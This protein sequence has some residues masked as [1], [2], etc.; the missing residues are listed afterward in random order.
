V[1]DSPR[2]EP[3]RG[4]AC[5]PLCACVRCV[6]VC[7][8]WVAPGVRCAYPDPRPSSPTRFLPPGPT[9]DSGAATESGHPDTPVSCAG[10]TS[11]GG[12]R[13]SPGCA[14]CQ[15]KLLRLL[16]AK[17]VAM[18]GVTSH[19]GYRLCMDEA[20]WE[21]IS[22]ACA[23]VPRSVGVRGGRPGSRLAALQEMNP[24]PLKALHPTAGPMYFMWIVSISCAACAAYQPLFMLLSLLHLDE[25]IFA[26]TRQNILLKLSYT[27]ASLSRQNILLNLLSKIF[28]LLS[29]QKVDRTFCLTPSSLSSTTCPLQFL[30]ETFSLTLPLVMHRPA[31]FS[32]SSSS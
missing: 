11:A 8:S 2:D 1:G 16:P 12:R 9:A 28:S 23:A 10:A 6:C 20:L 4:G 21:V 27:M 3:R 7:V 5:A 14:C 13:R 25:R 18:L 30:S 29:L 17:S 15:V 26:E 22:G 31:P 32:C 19:A 24:T